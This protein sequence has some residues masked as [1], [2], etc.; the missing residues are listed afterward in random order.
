MKALDE[1][2]YEILRVMQRDGRLSNARLAEM[3]NLSPAATYKRVRRLEDDGVIEGY[4]AD[5]A[6]DKLGFHMICYV[7]V[8]LHS[9]TTEVLDN[10]RK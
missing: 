10:F 5:L 1:I 8:S 7:R 4:R 6:L 3:I 9:H 2:D